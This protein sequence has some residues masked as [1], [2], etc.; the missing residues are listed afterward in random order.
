VADS[1]RSALPLIIAK[2]GLILPFAVFAGLVVRYFP[3][4]IRTRMYRLAFIYSP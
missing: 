4:D 3:S 2:C 1:K